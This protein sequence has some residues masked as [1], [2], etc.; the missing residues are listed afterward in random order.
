M[1]TAKGI[2]IALLLTLAACQTPA[3]DFCDVAEPIRLDA[4]T[5]DA[6][7]EEELDQ[8]LSQNRKG[9]AMCGWEP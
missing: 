4:A 8:A 1:G 3:G 5:V 6:L 7:S 2:A 9:E